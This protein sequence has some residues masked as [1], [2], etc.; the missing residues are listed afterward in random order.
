MGNK[1]EAVQYLQ[2]AYD[3]RAD[4]LLQMED[5]AAFNNLRDDPKFRALIA[6]VGLPPLT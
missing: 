1:R 3:Q 6:K 5:N 4:G 2:A